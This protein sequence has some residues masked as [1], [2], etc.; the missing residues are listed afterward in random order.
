MHGRVTEH[1]K[2]PPG[3]NTGGPFCWAMEESRLTLG[4]KGPGP[5]MC[6][7]G[8]MKAA[9]GADAFELLKLKLSRYPSLEVKPHS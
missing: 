6:R 9:N 7:S 2:S 5:S 8:I 1:E 3:V 4:A